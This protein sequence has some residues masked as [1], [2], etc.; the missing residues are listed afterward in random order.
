MVDA[1]IEIVWPHGWASVEQATRANLSLRL[2]RP[3]SLEPTPC[4]WAPPV[5]IWEA[6]DSE[7]GHKLT[8]AQPRQVGNT[9]ATLWDVN[10]LDVSYAQK[11]EA[12][13]Y[14]WVRI[15]GVITRTSVWA[16]AADPRTY[17]PQPAW[18]TAISTTMPIALDAR[19]LVVWPHDAAGRF[20]PVEK[21]DLA[22]VRVALYRPGTLTSIPPAPDLTVRLVGS[23]DNGVRR[24]IGI[25]QMRTIQDGFSY[26]VWDFDNVDVSAARDPR[27]RW[28]FWVEVDGHMTYSNVWM[29]GV[30]A[31]TYFPAVDQP[32]VG[33]RP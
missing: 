5:E 22:N 21:A 13:L 19:V 26:P 28:T 31:R 33:C 29:H 23:L 9:Q 15:P 30:D 11:R 20:Q 7:P 3:D 16:H 1:R 6:R 14:Y 24:T 4:G 25:G 32:I 10:D 27:S 17:Y 18:P 12:K 2:F 8:Q